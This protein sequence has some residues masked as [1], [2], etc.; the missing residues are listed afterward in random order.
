MILIQ[1]D[2]YAEYRNY[3]NEYQFLCTLLIKKVVSTLDS[4]VHHTIVFKPMHT[5][6]N[7][8]HENSISW[9]LLSL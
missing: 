3:P 1:L 7:L 6:I 8:D 9:L 4:K 5:I 2:E